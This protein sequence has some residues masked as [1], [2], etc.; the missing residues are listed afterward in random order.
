MGF[1][2]DTNDQISGEVTPAV[3][4]LLDNITAH[5]IVHSHVA[6]TGTVETGVETTAVLF[7][8]ITESGEEFSM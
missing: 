4:S 3:V 1:R 7:L 6:L 8:I 2:R 5:Q